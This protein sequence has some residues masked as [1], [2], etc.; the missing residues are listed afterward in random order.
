MKLTKKE[1]NEKVITNQIDI[2]PDDTAYINGVKY[3]ILPVESTD[4]YVVL[5][6]IKKE[7]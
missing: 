7:H 5:K 3:K 2:R 1:F 6:E 4:T